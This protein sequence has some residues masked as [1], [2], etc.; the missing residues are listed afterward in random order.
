MM[1]EHVR[2]RIYQ[3]FCKWGFHEINRTVL[4]NW[5]N[6]TTDDIPCDASRGN[7]VVNENCITIPTR[8]TGYSQLIFLYFMLVFSVTI[9]FSYVIYSKGGCIY[10]SGGDKTSHFHDMSIHPVNSVDI[11][12]KIAVTDTLPYLTVSTCWTVNASDF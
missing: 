5:T 12:I 11:N 7:D 6:F 3:K 9:C 1:S 10:N 8:I 2:P 4:N